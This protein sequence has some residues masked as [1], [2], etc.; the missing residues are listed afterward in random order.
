MGRPEDG[1][2]NIPLNAPAGDGGPGRF[3][4][5][6]PLDAT[7]LP[8]AERSCSSLDSMRFTRTIIEVEVATVSPWTGPLV[9]GAELHYRKNLDAPQEA[10]DRAIRY[11]PAAIEAETG[12]AIKEITGNSTAK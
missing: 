8:A 5:P 2:Q 10:V 9:I 11:A 12:Q 1:R 4:I 6:Q 3:R 7:Q